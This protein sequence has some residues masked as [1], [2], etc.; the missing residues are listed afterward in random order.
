MQSSSSSGL[1]PSDFQR[2][3]NSSMGN[4]NVDLNFRESKFQMTPLMIASLRGSRDIVL[5]LI[6]CGANL[7]LRDVKGYFSIQ[8]SF[9]C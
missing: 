8:M 6:K 3:Q 7:T 2:I 4:A 1:I 9:Y 5:L